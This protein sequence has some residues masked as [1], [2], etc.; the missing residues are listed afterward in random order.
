LGPDVDLQH[1]HQQAKS[2]FPRLDNTPGVEHHGAELRSEARFADIRRAAPRHAHVALTVALAFALLAALTALARVQAKDAGT[3]APGAST[4]T[5]ATAAT[6]PGTGATSTDGTAAPTTGGA[7]AVDPDTSS[8]VASAHGDAAPPRTP[9]N[10]VARYPGQRLLTKLRITMD[11][12]VVWA[13]ASLD[14]LH[15]VS[16]HVVEGGSNV[17]A[18]DDG[19]ALRGPGR[20]VVEGIFALPERDVEARVCKA[21]GGWAHLSVVRVTSGTTPVGDVVASANDDRL[22]EGCANRGATTLSAGALAPEGA[23]PVP[24]DDRR[25]V[26]SFFYPW[27]NTRSLDGN[28]DQEITLAPFE[29]VSDASLDAIIDSAKAAGVD[30]FVESYQQALIF[31]GK[32]AQ[33]VRRAE[34]DGA[35]TVAPQLELVYLSQITNGSGT[36]AALEGWFRD[37]LAS[38]A[39]PAYLKVGGRPVV[40]LFRTD[41]LDPGVLAA[42]RSNLRATGLDPYLIGDALD[43]A[44]ALDGFYTYTPNVVQDSV[45]LTDWYRQLAR[46][47]RYDASRAYGD[48]PALLV[49]PVSPGENDARAGG[50]SL[51]LVVDRGGGARYDAS[52]AAA[53]ATRPDWVVVS[54]WNA[55]PEDTQITPSQ[56]YGTRALEQTAAWAQIFHTG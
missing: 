31:S 52:W 18:L 9:R 19:I 25:L 5:S 30:G 7:L 40:F 46:T 14:G 24:V 34:A 17:D 35:F 54:S 49:S 50:G 21:S 42:V 44:Y 16:G 51:G 27:W 2:T 56:L 55:I 39:S 23:W 11:S 43:P 45:N 6:D 38:A 36:V 48:R 29:T 1:A 15:L 8:A 37:V 3:A 12:Q 41:L 28:P 20:G 22:V 32:F 47:T 53:V 10:A 33:L 4:V 13:A 26:L